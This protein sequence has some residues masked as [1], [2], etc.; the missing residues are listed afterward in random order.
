MRKQIMAKF[1]YIGATIDVKKNHTIGKEI[2]ISALNATVKTLVIPTNEEL[3]I[4]RDV[5]DRL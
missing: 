2:D 4:A 5:Y 3:M 1:N